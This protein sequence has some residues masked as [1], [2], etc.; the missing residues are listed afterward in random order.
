MT[1]MFHFTVFHL[2][3]VIAFLHAF[4]GSLLSKKF[5]YQNLV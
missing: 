2:F 4:G 1:V 3:L 5:F